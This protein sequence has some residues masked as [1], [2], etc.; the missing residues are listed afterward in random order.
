MFSG[1]GIRLLRRHRRRHC[2]SC[3]ARTG[4]SSS[5]SHRRRR[6]GCYLPQPFFVPI[7]VYVQQPVYVRAAAE[8][9]HF[10]QHP[11]TTVINNVINRPPQPGAGNVQPNARV[12]AAPP[13]VKGAP[14][15]G[16]VTQPAPVRG[17]A[18][19]G[20]AKGLPDPARQTAV[21]PSASINPAARLG[22]PAHQL[23][24]EAAQIRRA[25]KRI[26]QCAAAGTSVAEG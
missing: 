3:A 19:R 6:S 24:R 13:A 21:P 12:L 18:A 9:H 26:P 17:A 22:T 11:H 23:V 1:T 4:I 20:R 5:W 15:Q 14:G 25:H 7:P 8:Q 2:F 10:R 16:N